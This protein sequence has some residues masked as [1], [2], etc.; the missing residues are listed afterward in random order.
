[1]KAVE[2]HPQWRVWGSRAGVV[3]AEGRSDRCTAQ[4]RCCVVRGHTQRHKPNM[5]F[6]VCTSTYCML[7][8]MRLITVILCQATQWGASS[9][10]CSSLR[11]SRSSPFHL[12]PPPMSVDS[13]HRRHMA[14]PFAHMM[15]RTQYEV[16]FLQ[17][18][19]DVE[20]TLRRGDPTTMSQA[21]VASHYHQ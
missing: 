14:A 12:P 9:W 16:R 4:A 1:M 20:F 18:E 7:L 10:I 19:H 11:C 15:Q 2:L 6:V 5:S 13:P 8:L 17:V 3:A 21:S